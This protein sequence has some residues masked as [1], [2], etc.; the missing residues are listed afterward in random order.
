[1]GRNRA[2]FHESA[3]YHGSTHPFKV[4]DV[5]LPLSQV[6]PEKYEHQTSHGAKP[7]Y[8]DSAFATNSPLMASTYATNAGKVYKVEPV[9]H[10][11]VKTQRDIG[12]IGEGDNKHSVRYY[13]S[14]KGFKVTG[15]H[16]GS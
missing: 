5:V 2:D 11:E 10:T 4:G 15:E 9:D 16:S 14:K 12:I 1:M 6:N 3:M 8:V 7:Q 13:T